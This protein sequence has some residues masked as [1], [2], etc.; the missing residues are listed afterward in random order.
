MRLGADPEIFLTNHKHLV[1]AL[2][3]IGGTKY[4]P[5]QI[6]GL[7]TG[8]TLQEDNVS[9]EFGI[10][11]ASDAHEFAQHIHTVLQAGL[12]AAK[13]LSFSKLSCAVFPDEELKHPGA[14]IFGCE[15]DFN[16]WTK[17]KNDP[18]SLTNP[19]IRSAGGHIHFESD[20]DFIAGVRAADLFLSVPSVLMDSGTERKQ[21]YG[22]A[23]AF[24]PKSYGFE[25]RSLSN[26]W[27]FED[28]LVE[29]VWHNS[30]K[31]LEFAKKYALTWCN[32]YGA[33]VQ[34]CINT[35]DRTQAEFL[36]KEFDL[37]V[38]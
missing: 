22:K 2:G 14:H 17:E 11:P 32:D 25:Y 10:P 37:Y 27:V 38:A 24:R 18:P 21:L 33:M 31:A 26:F 6:E 4:D 34:D 12:L 23:G 19:N 8:F 20:V 5:L 30:E 1:S 29:W 9:L 35:N 16:A 13:G 36:I 3:K 7:P 15:P 28:R